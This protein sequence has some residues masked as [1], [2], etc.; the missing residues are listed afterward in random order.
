MTPFEA[1]DQI[2]TILRELER[3]SQMLV[4]DVIIRRTEITRMDDLRRR[5]VRMIEVVLELP[6]HIPNPGEG[7]EKP[8]IK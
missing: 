2:T 1:A 3:S 5:H 8:Q 6:E 7:W 4:T